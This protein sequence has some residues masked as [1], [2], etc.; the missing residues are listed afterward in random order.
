V[1]SATRLKSLLAVQKVG[2]EGPFMFEIAPNGSTK[3]MLAK[4]RKAR[5]HMEKLLTI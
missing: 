4:A 5:E 1:S 3:D 2:Y